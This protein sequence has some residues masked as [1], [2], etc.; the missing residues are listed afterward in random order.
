MVTIYPVPCPRL[1]SW[2]T[3]GGVKFPGLDHPGLSGPQ[4]HESFTQF[5]DQGVQALHCG[6]L[7]HH[8]SFGETLACLSLCGPAQFQPQSRCGQMTRLLQTSHRQTIFLGSWCT[9]AMLV[10]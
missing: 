8:S 2:S 1:P 5:V 7:S 3:L 4:T 10:R 6:W 9:T